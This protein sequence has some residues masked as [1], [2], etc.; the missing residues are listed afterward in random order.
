M[1][2]VTLTY[3]GGE[4]SDTGL[5]E[6]LMFGHEFVTHWENSTIPHL[7]ITIENQSTSIYHPQRKLKPFLMYV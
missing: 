1:I 5:L 2:T 3:A 6:P 7:N 4:H